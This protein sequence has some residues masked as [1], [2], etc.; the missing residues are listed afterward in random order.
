VPFTLENRVGRL[1]E[2]CM[3]ERMLLDEAQQ[4]RIK[5]YLLLSNMSGKVIVLCDMLRSEPF[6]VEVGDK[7]LEMLKTDNPKIE[8]TAFVMKEGVFATQIER[9]AMDAERAAKAEKKPPPQRRVFKDKLLARLWLSE[10]LT[11]QENARL[12][13]LVDDMP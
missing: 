8:R 1:V 9:I 3:T 2:I 12:H 10:A 11:L 4:I 5:M 13:E 7:M 6:G